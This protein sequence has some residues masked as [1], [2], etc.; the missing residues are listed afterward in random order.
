MLPSLK[1]QETASG[2]DD[3]EVVM[4][5]LGLCAC[6]IC[7][8]SPTNHGLADTASARSR[9]RSEARATLPSKG[10]LPTSLTNWSDRPQ[11]SSQRLLRQTESSVPDAL[12][13][14]IIP[15][16]VECSKL[17]WIG[18]RFGFGLSGVTPG[19]L[20]WLTIR[21]E[22]AAA[23]RRRLAHARLDSLEHS[24]VVLRPQENAQVY[25]PGCAG[26]ID[27]RR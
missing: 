27:S 16:T 25:A 26:E 3:F 10:H 11:K 6:T 2:T 1:S 17:G 19:H 22:S 13:A 5:L 18:L 12:H 14:A 8:T 15:L 4:P 20:E 9:K 7:G 24:A 21:R 23:R